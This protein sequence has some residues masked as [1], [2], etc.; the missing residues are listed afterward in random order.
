MQTREGRH[1]FFQH[2]ESV[3]A[4]LALSYQRIRA[5]SLEDPGTAGDG[6]ELHWADV[7]RRWLPATLPVVT[8]G[9]LLFA[10]GTSSNQIDIIVLHPSYP[11][12]LR[13]KTYYFAG[14]VLAAIEC[15]LTLRHDDIEKAFETGADIK[16]RMRKTDAHGVPP[17]PFT[18]LMQ[19]PIYSLISHSHGWK[20]SDPIKSIHKRVRD[21]TFKHAKH[22]RELIDSLCIADVAT[23]HMSKDILIGANAEERDELRELEVGKAVATCYVFSQDS[24]APWEH[25]AGFHLAHYI[26]DLTR[27]I[28]YKMPEI[29]PWASHV[30]GIAVFGGIGIPDYWDISALSQA[31]LLQLRGMSDGPSEWGI[32]NRY[33]P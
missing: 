14:G 13:N 11:I 20:N 17:N 23:F 30:G 8:K 31:T 1:D 16:R 4:D 2:M 9:R 21:C 33:T 10:D 15:K 25:N 27:R 7:L 22:P 12:G 18:E 6:A 29:Q 3:S 24:M 32:W 26:Y 19:Y 28:G 5:R